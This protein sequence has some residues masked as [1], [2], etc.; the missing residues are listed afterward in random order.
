M[1]LTQ[2]VKYWFVGKFPLPA[3][4]GPIKY[5]SKARK[6]VNLHVDEHFI[7]IHMS[8]GITTA[9]LCWWA[10]SKSELL[11]CPFRL[12]T[13]IISNSVRFLPSVGTG[14]WDVLGLQDKSPVNFKVPAHYR[15]WLLSHSAIETRFVVFCA[16][17]FLLAVGIQNVLFISWRVSR[18]GQSLECFALIWNLQTP[19][20]VAST[21]L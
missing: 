2:G 5:S 16:L 14:V 4:A 13:I 18:S 10:I 19:K 1:F 11:G 7:V 20:R 15:T 17:H 21:S 8:F 6:P 9:H 12:R 3:G